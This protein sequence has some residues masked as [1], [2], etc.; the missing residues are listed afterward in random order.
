EGVVERAS[1]EK[2]REELISLLAHYKLISNQDFTVVFDG[3]EQK[4]YPPVPM[5]QF[6]QGIRVMFSKATTA[7]EDIISLT[8]RF[9]NPKEITV[10]TSDNSIL[11]A[12][13]RA[14]CHTSPPEEFYKKITLTL[15]KEKFTPTR[16]PT[17]K[18]Q[19]LPEH[20]VKYWLKFFQKKLKGGGE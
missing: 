2:A 9:P 10:I 17:G 12:T 11:R 13:A 15:K 4:E 14:G 16:E 18:Y 6:S 3:R 5:E 1:L 20:E 19:E 7:D 8:E